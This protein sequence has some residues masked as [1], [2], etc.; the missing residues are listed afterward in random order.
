[1]LPKQDEETKSQ[2]SLC[3]EQKG[4]KIS[5][6]HKIICAWLVDP[7]CGKTF[8]QQVSE[9]VELKGQT[10]E[11]QW[12]TKKEL[13]STMDESEAEEMLECGAIEWRRN[14]LN[15]KRLQFKK[16]VVKETTSVQKGRT[17][18]ISGNQ[19][20]DPE[21][22]TGLNKQL[23][24]LDFKGDRLIKLADRGKLHTALGGG[25]ESSEED[26]APKKDKN[27]GKPKLLLKGKPEACSESEEEDPE[28]EDP[29]KKNK[30][31]SAEVKKL[32]AALAKNLLALSSSLTLFQ[33][34]S[35]CVAKKVK[36]ITKVI[37]MGQKCK[38]ELDKLIIQGAKPEKLVKGKVIAEEANSEVLAEQ[39]NLKKVLSA[40]QVSQAPTK[41]TSSRKK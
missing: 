8:K 37:E 9:V 29:D 22:Y 4:Q 36:E 35:F 1:V 6:Q 13:L 2:W 5:L 30:E 10:K 25:Q 17:L 26:E 39:A 14:P 40:D 32:S 38:N 7:T 23:E 19:E 16:V 3:S 12:V 34:S 24:R 11:S 41:A 20:T 21:L 15:K 28:P 18:R 27:K 33:K 31:L